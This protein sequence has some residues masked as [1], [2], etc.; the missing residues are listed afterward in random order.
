MLSLKCHILRNIIIIIII[1]PLLVSQLLGN[2]LAYYSH[3]QAKHSVHVPTNIA[4]NFYELTFIFVTKVGYITNNFH[5]PNG[6][7]SSVLCSV[8]PGLVSLRIDMHCTSAL[9]QPD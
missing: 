1:V 8:H 4:L 3:I 5:S 7:L 6:I 9:P 2:G